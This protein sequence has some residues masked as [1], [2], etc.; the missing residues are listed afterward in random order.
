[1]RIDESNSGEEREEGVK[2][3]TQDERKLEMREKKSKG[4]K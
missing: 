3:R 2:E 1:M 4:R